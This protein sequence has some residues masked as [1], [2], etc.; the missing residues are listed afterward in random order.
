MREDDDLPRQDW[1]WNLSLLAILATVGGIVLYGSDL[2]WGSVRAP[3]PRYFALGTLWLGMGG[4]T[5]WL[6]SQRGRSAP[7]WFALG[8]AL[9]PFALLAVGLAPVRGSGR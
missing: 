8:L 2:W 4:L 1:G 6:A 9:G 7:A 5:G 3:D